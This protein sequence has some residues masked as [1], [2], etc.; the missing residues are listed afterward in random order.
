[1]WSITTHTGA[2]TQTQKHTPFTSR[3]IKIVLVAGEL[4]SSPNMS[5]QVENFHAQYRLG[6]AVYD[7]LSDKQFYRQNLMST[8]Q[9]LFNDF[10]QISAVGVAEIIALG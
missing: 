3:L 4:T 1:M 8:V 9:G 2:H 10:S 7:S 6:E 5:P